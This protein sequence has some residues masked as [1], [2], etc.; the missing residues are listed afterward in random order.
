[1][2]KK[3]RVTH[4]EN[5]EQFP[6][7]VRSDGYS[8]KYGASNITFNLGAVND[9][10]IDV[11]SLRLNFKLQVIDTDGS[12]SY[13]NN[14]D[15]YATG[16]VRACLI[17]S[18]TGVNGVISTLRVTNGNNSVIS[19]IRNYN[20]LLT[21]L[22][23]ANK[24]F[25]GYKSDVSVQELAFAR[26]ETQGLAVNGDMACSVALRAGIFQDKAINLADMNGMVID[27]TLAPDNLF[28]YGA[29]ASDC[30]YRLRDVSLSW[31][32]L[33]LDAPLPPSN[34]VF[35]YPLYRNFLNIIQSSDAT[36]TLNMNLGSVRNVHSTF[37]K[38]S[39]VN[40]F[41][42]NSFETNQLQDNGGVNKAVKEYSHRRNNVRYNNNFNVTERVAL[43]NGVY[44]ALLG[45]NGLN[46][47]QPYDNITSCLQAPET[48]LVGARTFKGITVGDQDLP[49]DRDL[50]IVG[51]NYDQ[52]FVG[53]GA[54]FERSTYGLRLE[55]ELDTAEAN[56]MYSYGL[57]NAQLLVSKQGQNVQQVD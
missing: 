5:A 25:A 36:T 56:S 28:L 41:A 49:D 34:E 11:N 2:S 7:N 24:S 8:F 51:V 35:Q 40:N 44:P 47:I 29:N 38:S 6:I 54:D 48:Q 22:L 19:E 15:T 37:I 45:R 57:A 3:V 21:S 4:I 13:V 12:D 52:L 10:L 31:K 33:V 39:Q 17:D 9:R 42:T 16:S 30:F 53:F 14:Q 20:R 1:M 50:Y 32:W 23:P 26:E 27:I 43:T 18:R 46:A 55:S